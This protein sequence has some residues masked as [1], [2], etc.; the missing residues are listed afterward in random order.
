MRAL[1]GHDRCSITCGDRTAHSSRA[2][3]ATATDATPDLPAIVADTVGT[4][5]PIFP[6][7]PNDNSIARALLRAPSA[8]ALKQLGDRQIGSAISIPLSFEG[9]P[10]V[11]IRCESRSPREPNF[12]LHAAAELFAQMLALRLEID[13]LGG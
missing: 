5:V 6:R 3:S 7:R 8:D 12:E 9:R 1:S 4:P 11:H 13:R 2:A 10:T